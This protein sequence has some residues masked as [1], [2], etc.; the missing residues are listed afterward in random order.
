MKAKVINNRGVTLV[1]VL[2]TMV[3]LLSV[4]GAGLLFSGVN[5]K[6]TGNYQTGT[7][8]FYAADTGINAALTQLQ[9]N[10]TNSTVAIPETKVTGTSD[11]YYQSESLQFK[12]SVPPPGYSLGAGT[13]YNQSGYAFYQYQMNMK[14]YVKPTATEL[15]TRRVEAQATYG[16]VPQ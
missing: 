9:L 2:M 4:I 1:V 10:Q 11:S 16:P 6:I 13:G 8:A 3:M 14:G 12:G 15:A 7:R 5:L